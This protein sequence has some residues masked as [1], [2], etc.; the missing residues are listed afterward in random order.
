MTDHDDGHDGTE[1]W[2]H[3]IV[4]M[5]SQVVATFEHEDDAYAWADREYDTV[6]D[7]P[8]GEIDGAFI[9]EVERYRAHE[10]PANL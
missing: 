1:Y 9:T 8:F 10:R 5:T 6:H 3:E 2:V 4:H 7:Y